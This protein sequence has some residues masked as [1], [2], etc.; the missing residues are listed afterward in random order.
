[1]HYSFS[2]VSL[3]LSACI[4]LVCLTG[5]LSSAYAATCFSE[6]E[7]CINAS[8]LCAFATKEKPNSKQLQ[9]ETKKQFSRHVL[10]AK[11]IGLSCGVEREVDE[12]KKGF[13]ALAPLQKKEAQKQL[14]RLGLYTDKIDGFYGRNTAAGLKIYNYTYFKNTDLAKASNAQKLLNDLLQ[15]RTTPKVASE[16][17]ESNPKSESGDIIKSILLLG[18]GALAA[19][20]GG[21]DAFIEG[22]SNGVSG[23]SSGSSQTTSNSSSGY[24]KPSGCSSDFSCSY[25]QK[26]LKKMG[27]SVGVCKTTPNRS[28][29][30]PS[31]VLPGNGKG[32]RRSSECPS[33]YRCDLTYRACVR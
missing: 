28:T 10:L 26:C 13:N 6:P 4:L 8:Q 1:M 21:G 25:G 30:S 23:S 20:N 15:E 3:Q 16:Q 22:F 9:W 24:F 29:F 18:L 14:K 17:T 12:L 33:G 5:F 2:K 31:S 32:C 7:A 19:A 11:R 27:Q